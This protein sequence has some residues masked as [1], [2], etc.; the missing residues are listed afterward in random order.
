MK[1]LSR[2]ILISSISL[3]SGGVLYWALGWL[4]VIKHGYFMN[5]KLASITDASLDNSDFVENYLKFCDGVLGLKTPKKRECAFTTVKSF[6]GASY[7][8]R[9]TIAFN[10][11]PKEEGKFDIQVRSRILSDSKPSY[12]SPFSVSHLKSKGIN[13][14]EARLKVLCS[15]PD[16]NCDSDKGLGVLKEILNQESQTKITSALLQQENQIAL[17]VQDQYG[18]AQK[19]LS[20]KITDCD[21]SEDSRPEK[22]IPLKDKEKIHCLEEKISTQSQSFKKE[23][24]KLRQEIGDLKK[25]PKPLHRSK[26]FH[27]HIKNKIWQMVSHQNPLGPNWFMMEYMKNLPPLFDERR[28]AV[29]S[30]LDLMQKYSHFRSF[31]G[32][33]NS[34]K[35]SQAMEALL[36]QLPE[37]LSYNTESPYWKKDS[38]FLKKAFRTNFPDYEES[39]FPN[40]WHQDTEKPPL[41]FQNLLERQH[42]ILYEM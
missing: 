4:V 21:I 34:D 2:I 7:K 37:H 6:K 23:L 15:S 27:D 22:H 12:I 19:D 25:T 29:R 33:L 42:S 26:Y 40:E 5:H 36:P 35:Q 16:T 1:K 8:V 20:Q 24:E 3:V 28:F 18:Q 10:K 17:R 30:S 38:Y 14:T 39:F 11:K 31:M 13:I 9:S 32:G 41:D